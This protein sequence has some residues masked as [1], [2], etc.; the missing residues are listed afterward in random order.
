MTPPER[1][2]TRRMSPEDRLDQ[3]SGAAMSVVAERGYPGLTLDQVA[4]RAGVTRNLIYHYFPRGRLDLFL[5]A[6]D[7]AGRRLTE[8]WVTDG[9]IPLDQRLDA[10]FARIFEHALKP[11][12]A[13]LVHRQ[14]RL[15]GEPE[16]TALGERYLSRVIAAISLNHL[17][18][19]EPPPL[20]RSAM[21]AYLDF[22]ERTL[23][24]CRERDLDRD[25]VMRVLGETLLAVA[26]SVR[27]A[28]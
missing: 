6:L 24:E 9:A 18:T 10:N 20:A 21:R 5:A 25:A 11:S 26:A 19:D 17:G 13:W 2:A 28:G 12:E 7:R 23:D 27:P 22:A 1:I 16:V 14:G 15:L 4:E 8:G 3:L